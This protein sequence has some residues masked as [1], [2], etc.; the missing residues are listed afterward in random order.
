MNK[1]I[2]S[3]CLVLLSL[4]SLYS[5]QEPVPP[6]SPLETSVTTSTNRTETLRHEFRKE[7]VKAAEGIWVAVGYGAANST[8]I[9]GDT[10]AIVIDTMYGTEAAGHVLAAFRE[11]TDK[12]IVAIIITHGHADHKGATSVFQD[13]GT[14]QIIARPPAEAT[15]ARYGELASIRRERGKRQFGSELDPTDK[16]D[17]IA[18]VYR[19]TGGV[20]AGVVEPSRHMETEREEVSIAGIDLVLLAGPGESPDHLLVWLPEK[21]VLF[22]GDN[23]YMSFPN[24]YA[25]RGTSYR[26]VSQWVDTLDAMIKLEAEVLITG[27]ARPVVGA[28][29]VNVMLNDYKEAIDH[30]LMATLEGANLGM[31]ADEL[32]A[33]VRLPGH[34]AEKPYLQEYYGVLEWSVRSIYT[35]YLGW[36]D[37]N[38]TQLFPLSPR[39]EAERMIRLAGSSAD[40]LDS[41]REALETG[42]YQW[43]CQLLDHLLVLT[44]DSRELKQLKASA[45]RFLATSQQSSNAHH[46]YLSSA[47]KLESR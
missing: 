43:A 4:I 35:G 5:C 23:F 34:L 33:T 29:T 14:P 8:L 19:P 3:T 21:R 26:D 6:A 20:Q 17:G 15:L 37:G 30:V 32:A 44:P 38:P 46:Y 24:L 25:I 9:E 36:F 42:D 10:G 31:T 1:L 27:H 28:S 41:A 7:I 2:K 39:S 40:L 16:L 18:P 11:V 12:P 22:G 47:E 13:G 45:L